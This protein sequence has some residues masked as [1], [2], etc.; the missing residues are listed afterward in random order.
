MMCFCDFHLNAT[1]VDEKEKAIELPVHVMFNGESARV[2][3]LLTSLNPCK[4]KLTDGRTYSIQSATR[5][6][7]HSHNLSVDEDVVADLWV[8]RLPDGSTRPVSDFFSYW[9]MRSLVQKVLNRTHCIAIQTLTPVKSVMHKAKRPKLDMSSEDEKTEIFCL[10][11]E[12]EWDRD[13]VEDAIC[14]DSQR[15]TLLSI[16]YKKKPLTCGKGN[17]IYMCRFEHPKS[18]EDKLV[19]VSSTVL[20]MVEAYKKMVLAFVEI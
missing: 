19:F 10:A 3:A 18:K 2:I 14:D 11:D 20:Y 17:P 13:M 4:L 8:V 1:F 9:P 12:D 16:E 15:P 5:L 6:V 7:S